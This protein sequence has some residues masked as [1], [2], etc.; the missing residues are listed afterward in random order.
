MC[1]HQLAMHG[2]DYT[3]WI[4]VHHG[5]IQA[6]ATTICGTLNNAQINGYCFVCCYF[7][8][9]VE[10]TIFDRDG[11]ADIVRVERFLQAGFELRPFSALNPKWIAGQQGFAEGDQIAA[12]R[13]GLM[14]PV[15]DF[16][17]CRVALQPD[18]RDLRQSDY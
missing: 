10:I 18:W 3:L 6:V 14:H 13:S 11:L 12:T 9:S 2:A 7:A 16:R 4:D 15:D 5:A 8:D 17:E 1:R